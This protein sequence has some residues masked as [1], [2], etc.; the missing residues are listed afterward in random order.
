VTYSN[1]LNEFMDIRIEWAYAP[2]VAAKRKGTWGGAREGAGRPPE[3]DDAVRFTFDIPRRDLDALRTLS[4]RVQVPAAALIREAV[5]R[6]L[7][8]S[9]RR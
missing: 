8:G 2:G 3:L 4:E 6:L 5:R 9:A 7:R 1:T